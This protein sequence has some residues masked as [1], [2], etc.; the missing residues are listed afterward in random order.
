MNLLMIGHDIDDLAK[1]VWVANTNYTIINMSPNMWGK[2]FAQLYKKTQDL[3][4]VSTEY[5][6]VAKGIDDFV[7]LVTK[8]NFVPVFVTDDKSHIIRCMH[9]AV[10]DLLPEAVL[11]MGD[12]TSERYP[13]L[14]A[15]LQ[16]L[17][18]M[19]G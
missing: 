18:K 8:Y 19:K 10:E 16:E 14:I 6:F 3:I 11:F 1:K 17:L 4:V 5:Q 12:E 9:T 13:E 7:E 2:E 15:M